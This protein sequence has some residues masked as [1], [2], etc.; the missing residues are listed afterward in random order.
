MDEV[1][2][3]SSGV[4]AIRHVQD[5]ADHRLH[6]AVQGAKEENADAERQMQRPF[7]SAQSGHDQDSQGHREG[8]QA[9]SDRGYLNSIGIVHSILKLSR[10]VAR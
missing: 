1:S 3:C 10:W 4:K 7:Q 6:L 8:G 5:G 2:H 9:N